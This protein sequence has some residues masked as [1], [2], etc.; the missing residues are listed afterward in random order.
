MVDWPILTFAKV[1][2]P[3]LP[4]KPLLHLEGEVVE[5]LGVQRVAAVVGQAFQPASSPDF[6][7]R[8]SC[9]SPAAWHPAPPATFKQR[10]GDWK[11]AHTGRLESLP[12]LPSRKALLQGQSSG[13]AHSRALTGFIVV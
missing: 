3:P 10:P 11:V 6:P 12:Y 5:H 7:V 13:L 2:L 1:L 8:C 9:V 4:P